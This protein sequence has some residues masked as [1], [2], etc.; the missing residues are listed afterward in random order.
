LN[1]FLLKLPLTGILLLTTSSLLSII[2]SPLLNSDSDLDD[3]SKF[4][5]PSCLPINYKEELLSSKKDKNNFKA[6]GTSL[7]NKTSL[8]VNVNPSSKVKKTSSKIIESGSKVNI[9]FK[10]NSRDLDL[11]DKNLDFINESLDLKKN[12]NLVNKDLDLKI[13]LDLENNLNFNGSN[14]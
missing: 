5:G 11:V 3:S 14:Y 9:S 13:S 8:K 7:K 12:L 6:N 2:S 10:I 4:S 1:I